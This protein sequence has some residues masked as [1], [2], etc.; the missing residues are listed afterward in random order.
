MTLVQRQSR[1]MSVLS[2]AH[3]GV[4]ANTAEKLRQQGN[5]CYKAGKLKQGEPERELLAGHRC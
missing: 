5:D 2:S 1:I 4:D 3:T